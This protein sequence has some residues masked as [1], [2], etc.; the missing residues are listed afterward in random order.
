MCSRKLS[1]TF[2]H[3]FVLIFDPALHIFRIVSTP[4]YLFTGLLQ[5]IVI[6]K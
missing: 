3:K 1:N 5:Y 4:L 2:I 6:G